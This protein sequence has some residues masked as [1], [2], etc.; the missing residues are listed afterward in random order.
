MNCKQMDMKTTQ[1]VCC[2]NCGGM[3][4]RRN[5]IY[6]FSDCDKCPRSQVVRT[7]CP[8][9]DYVMTICAIGC[10]V[11]EAYAPGLLVSDCFSSSL[12]LA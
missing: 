11:V 9:C 6:Q 10:D 2:P 12:K 7:E 1:T 8:H 4:E 3:A 5:F